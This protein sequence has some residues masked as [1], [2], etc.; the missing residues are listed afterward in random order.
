M[1]NYKAVMFDF[2]YTLGDATDAIFAGFTHALSEL[3]YPAPQREPVRRTVGM[4]LEDAFTLLTGNGDVDERARFHALFAGIARPLQRAG[5]PLC[6]G[7]KALLLALR[8]QGVVTA[9]VST[10]HTDTLVHIL[11]GHGLET[12]PALVVGG[13]LVTRSKP[14]PEGLNWAMERLGLAPEET[15]FCGDTTIDAE[16]AQRAGTDF[17]AVL[18]GTT[19]AESFKGYPCCYVAEDLMALRGF[20]EGTPGKEF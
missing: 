8:D 19:P 13:D 3:G 12:V 1:K 11:A 20:L 17:C 5:V 9:V 14:D 7:A 2:D 4:P 15:L 18:N 10:K 6:P 16:T